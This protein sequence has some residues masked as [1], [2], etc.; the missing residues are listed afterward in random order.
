[1]ILAE[2]QVRQFLR[3]DRK[4]L[5]KTEHQA[6]EE[7]VELFQRP[8]GHPLVLPLIKQLPVP[9]QLVSLQVIHIWAAMILTTLLLIG[10]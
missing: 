3:L 5:Y 4:Y 7:L 2:N 10:W 9:L 6:L 8:H 1:M